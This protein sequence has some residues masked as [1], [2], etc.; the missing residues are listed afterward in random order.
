MISGYTKARAIR[1]FLFGLL[2]VIPIAVH[3]QQY[4]ILHVKGEILR[5]KDGTLLKLGD[6]IDSNEKINFKS[7]D[8]MAAVLS[9]EK[10][11]FIL[12]AD[13]KANEQG[14]LTYILKATV[15]PVRGGMSTRAAGINNL[16]DLKVY[17][18]EAP[19]VWA[20]DN[21]ILYISTYAFPMN[22]QQ[23]FY[24]QYNFKG[25]SINKVLDHEDEKLTF[26]KS[27]LFRIDDKPVNYDDI[28]NYKLF[29]Y[30]SIKE[31]SSLISTIRFVLID[32]QSLK[33]I[34]DQYQDTREDVFYEMA[35]MFS[36]LYGKCDALQLRY[37]L[38][39]Q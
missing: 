19:F 6:K 34:Y 13:T 4:Q 2:F 32:S 15:S 24:M 26:S 9:A 11:R 29:Y 39:K 14:D 8:A 23:F 16:L 36:D 28:D 35:D 5:V 1:G 18:E 7:R 31:E 30:D 27:S 20:G 25:E 21:I 17:F 38:L 12:K 3:C 37:N 33:N 22:E 10:G